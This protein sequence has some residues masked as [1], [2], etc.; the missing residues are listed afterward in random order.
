MPSLSW[1]AAIWSTRGPRGGL[2]C[3]AHPRAQAEWGR[4]G[5]LGWEGRFGWNT[6][7]DPLADGWAAEGSRNAGERAPSG[8][9]SVCCRASAGS[10]LRTPA[11]D[12]PRAR[13]VALH[14]AIMRLFPRGRER[15]PWARSETR[16][17][18]CAP[19]GTTTNSR[20]SRNCSSPALLDTKLSSR[21]PSAGGVNSISN[22][23]PG[24]RCSPA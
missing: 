5:P 7:A 3:R 1:P 15:S 23:N 20:V 13:D 12:S 10:P 6:A 19:S 18:Y 2:M 24:P 4:G 16:D 14:V 21:S 22:G 11:Y 17:G 9:G 8:P